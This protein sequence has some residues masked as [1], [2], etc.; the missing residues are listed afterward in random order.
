MS[1]VVVSLLMVALFL[2]AGPAP[3]SGADLPTVNGAGSTFA[4]LAIQQWIVDVRR[5]GLSIN[6]QQV[7]STAGRDRFAKRENADFASSDVS[8]RFPEGLGTEAVPE[9]PY[10]YMPLVGGG[11]AVMYS[12]KDNAGQAI[13]GLKLS[14][15][16]LV[17]IFTS[18]YYTQ[19]RGEP[20]MFWDD[21]DIK[22]ENP[23][24]AARLPHHPIYPVVRKGGSGTTSVFTEYLSKQAGDRWRG[25]MEGGCARS[26]GCPGL[27]PASPS[28]DCKNNTCGATDEWPENRGSGVEYKNGSDTV[29]ITVQ[30]GQAGKGAIGYAEYAYA[31]QVGLPVV[32]LKNASG[33]YAEPTACSQAIA[34]TA[35]RR[36]SDGTYDLTD[37]YAHPH[38][39]AYP[40]S[41]YNYIIVPTD[42]YDA[43]K[44]EVISKF[45]LHA[46]TDG[47]KNVD[48]IGYSQLPTELINQGL[49][50]L[51][52][53]P[54]H[55]A[56]P[57]AGDQ[58]GQ[59]YKSLAL[60][61][62]QKCGE[63][64]EEAVEENPPGNNNQNQ[65]NEQNNNNNDQNNENN[66]NNNSNNNN[67]NN[68]QNN[69]AS[70]S[71][72]PS[73]GA[74]GSGGGGSGGN[75]S[76]SAKP[77]GSSPTGGS[78][79]PGTGG[80]GDTGGTG[81]LTPDSEDGG[82]GDAPGTGTPTGQET[83]A[84]TGEGT[85]PGVATDGQVLPLAGSGTGGGNSSI[86]PQ[87]AGG[88]AV[89]VK[90]VAEAAGTPW[91]LLTM[92]LALVAVVF[93]PALAGTVARLRRA[94][95]H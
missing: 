2:G 48:Q 36:K 57:T 80:T 83:P 15:P 47:Q 28:E 60:P 91:T 9:F 27:P 55:P 30:Q 10:T 8:Y 31:I 89:E 41:S 52:S 93:G 4:Y 74:S 45:T 64:G 32:K 86:N 13:T 6:Y 78:G 11:T 72:S 79:K 25:Y 87:L 68:A 84:V 65:N 92:V 69:S 20:E 17:K 56:L 26:E 75:P 29:A 18:A 61:N 81:G 42:G 5:Q 70:P 53:V 7:G 3:A 58:W 49:S 77:G 21:A 24:I 85:T 82:G 73:P 12:I 22:A 71:A 94:R 39:N 16:L 67:N 66:S 38:A 14:G 37:V 19:Y 40:I 50:A 34:L 35:A 95:R 46:I 54:G 59:Y 63:E 33:N 44:G 88:A 62:G 90:K 51:A 1:R 43:A 23:E 76:E